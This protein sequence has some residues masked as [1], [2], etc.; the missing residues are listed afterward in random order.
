M[1]ILI[2]THTSND[3]FIYNFLKWLTWSRPD[4]DVEVFEFYSN[5][6]QSYDVKQFAAVTT[7]PLSTNKLLRFQLPKFFSPFYIYYHLKRFLNNK[8]YDI[9]QCHWIIAPV[10]ISSFMK[11][12][13]DRLYLT[14]WGGELNRTKSNFCRIF[15]SKQLYLL[16]LNRL[17]K[18]SDGIINSDLWNKSIL[19]KYPFL[20][21]KLYVAE[22]GSTPL[23]ALY[24]LM[25]KETKAE[26]KK[27]MGIE[28]N[29]LT[30]LIGY[31]G[32][33]LHQHIPIIIELAKNVRLKKQI[34]LMVP[35]T[36]DA[37]HK[38]I[39]EVKRQLDESGYSYTL[40]SGS[41]LSDEDVARLRNATDITLQLSIFD[42]YS[43]SIVE[44]LCAKSYLI[45]GEWLEC[46]KDSLE[47]DEFY[48]ESAI[49][50]NDAIIKL[51]T[52]VNSF[53]LIAKK[54]EI[55][56]EKGKGRNLWSVCIK[57][58]VAIYSK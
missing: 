5:V 49:S 35:M 37:S 55:N 16:Y 34:H 25:G 13:C 54:L 9:I 2:V 20:K 41:F 33:Q 4:W 51:E 26:S 17:L 19:E 6:K 30:V 3:I 42:G 22:F 11:H 14:F 58:W 24:E 18:V 44:C 38:Y 7:V 29:K 40:L 15:H 47:K 32:K 52:I 53:N 43:R 50:I 31:S 23:E 57:D 39:N 21:N 1:K 36:R 10:V 45:Y 12:Y 8:Y 56:H 27:K 48:A 46:Y 28:N